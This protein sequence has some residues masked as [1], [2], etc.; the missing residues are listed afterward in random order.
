MR[1]KQYYHYIAKIYDSLRP[2]T[3]GKPLYLATKNGITFENIECL[4]YMSIPNG[5]GSSITPKDSQCSVSS[6]KIDIINVEYTISQWFYERL[7]SKD[8]MTY[9]EMVDIFVLLGDGSTKLI[10][11]GLIRS[12]DNDEFESKYTFEIAD[13]QDRLKSSIFDR[14]L[15]KYNGETIDDINKYRMP[16]KIINGKRIGFNIKEVDEGETDEN[17][18]PIL[19]RIITFEGHPIDCIELIFQA[20]FSTA[21]LEVQVPYLTNQYQ[22]FVDLISLNEIK[23][24]LNRPYYY[25]YYLEIREPIDDPY[26]WLIENIYKPCTIF[27]YLSLDGKLGIKLHRQPIIGTEGITLNETN[28]IS[29]DNKNITDENIVN[30]MVVKYNKDFKEDKERVKRYFTSL[31]S[32]NKFRMLIPSSP[33]EY[34]I[35]GINK[36]S[37]TDKATFAAMLS[38]SIF[39]RYGYPGIEIEVTVPLEIAIDYKVGDYLFIEHK[40]LVS[41]EGEKPGTS[42]IKTNKEVIDPYNKIA[43]LDVNHEWGAFLIEN[44]LGKSIDG[45]WIITT[46]EKEITHKIF[47][48]QDINFESCIKNHSRIEKW[49]KNEGVI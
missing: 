20:I 13:F 28:I 15:S 34:V 37:E 39:S 46:K 19:T 43:F 7:N 5:G 4:P 12:I 49:L 17:N 3:A 32:F 11:R 36:L 21:K 8:S 30:N 47:N 44:T 45:T 25:N 1:E 27:P 26:S 24:V 10:Y 35:A 31:G 2:G 33:D 18:N 6:I 48:S 42:G 22:D 16:F 38:D 29:I 14:E 9:G 41:W 40:T 23:K